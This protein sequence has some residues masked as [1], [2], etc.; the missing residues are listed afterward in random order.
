MSVIEQFWISLVIV[1]VS[2]KL[3]YMDQSER[4]YPS[5][6]KYQDRSP[7]RAEN[8]APYLLTLL[9]PVY[10]AFVVAT[11]RCAIAS[12]VREPEPEH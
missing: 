3:R 2:P 12:S 4:Q 5:S 8:I 7:K 9:C 11:A 10:S 6:P 1:I